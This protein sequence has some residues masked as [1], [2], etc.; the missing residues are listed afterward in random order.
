VNGPVRHTMDSEY[1]FV[2]WPLLP[3]V[4]HFISTLWCLVLHRRKQKDKRQEL[5]SQ[6]IMF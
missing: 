4:V 3:L 2:H 1:Y 5:Y 6:K